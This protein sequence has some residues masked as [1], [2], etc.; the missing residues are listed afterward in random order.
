MRWFGLVLLLFGLAGCGRTALLFHAHQTNAD[1]GPD[2]PGA[3]LLAHDLPPPD[4]AAVD[5]SVIDQPGSDGAAPA[6]G[7]NALLPL[8][9]RGVLT[10][11]H[12]R[13]VTFAPDR[14]W[15]VLR[16]QAEAPPGIG[17][18]D[19]LIRVSLP[20]GELATISSA[21]GSAE[22]LGRQGGLLVVGADSSG[23]GLAV[24][25]AGGLRTLA[26]NACGHL[27]T[28][29]GARLYAVRDCDA[30]VRGTLDVVDVA[31]GTTTTLGLGVYAPYLAVSPNS[32]WFA[33]VAPNADSGVGANTLRVADRAGRTY[34]IA[35]QPSA[36]EP[37]FASD[38]VLLFATNSSYYYPTA[39]ASLRGHVPGSGDA[40]YLVASG[41][42]PGFYGYKVSPDRS[43]LL[44]A[45]AQVDAGYFGTANLYATR[46]D[47]SAEYLLSP[48]LAAFWEYQMALDAFAWS[49][50]GTRAIFLDSRIAGVSTSDPLGTS[51]SEISTG[52]IFRV[53]PVGD[54]VALVERSPATSQDHL[55]LFALGTGTDVAA[56]DAPSY[57]G[58]P[59]FAPDG[60]GL[61]FVI[62]QPNG[63][64]ELRYISGSAPDSILLGTWTSSLLS[65]S[66]PAGDYTPPFGLYPIDPTGCFTLVDTDL[67]PG[68]GTRLVLLPE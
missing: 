12:T 63:P 50:D 5:A 19:Q 30:N 42:N 36:G 38:E 62:A 68:P 67:A 59:N 2:R 60:K 61:L 46:L 54:R 11:Q 45:G 64:S 10:S 27:A 22:A 16:A 65:T 66:S 1:A 44:A 49:G 43:W 47:G 32:R 8:A 55:R 17:Y 52:G 29:D 21:G 24:Y 37:S 58:A 33:F 41:R 28:P 3:D 7:C 20:G 51:V 18:P 34:E 56:L 15:I 40:S 48:D 13:E 57:I 35:S 14:S 39:G 23:Q 4:Q 6:N 9:A 25:E 31:S 53:A 26:S